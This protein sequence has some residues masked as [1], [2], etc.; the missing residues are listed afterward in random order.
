MT[1]IHTK[2][3]IQYLTRVRAVMFTEGGHFN[4]GNRVDKRISLE[5]LPTPHLLINVAPQP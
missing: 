3:G 4:L 1:N 5:P 2:T